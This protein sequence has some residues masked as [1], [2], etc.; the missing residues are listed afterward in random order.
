M[1]QWV[2]ELHVTQRVT[3]TLESGC[4]T[5]RVCLP[6]PLLSPSPLLSCLFF[7]HRSHWTPRTSGWIIES[8]P[9]LAFGRSFSSHQSVS[10]LPSPLQQN[11]VGMALLSPEEA[12]GGGDHRAVLRAPRGGRVKNHSR[13]PYCRAGFHYGWGLTPPTPPGGTLHPPHHEECRLRGA[14][15]AQAHVGAVAGWVCPLLEGLAS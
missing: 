9:T 10:F 6:A 11:G 15:G 4:P 14:L 12:A 2:R 8:L 7:L 3:R 5:H 13:S 1:E